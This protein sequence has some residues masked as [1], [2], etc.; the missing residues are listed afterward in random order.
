MYLIHKKSKNNKVDK[1]ARI[2]FWLFVYYSIVHIPYITFN[3]YS[4]PMI[5]IFI[6]SSAFVLNNIISKRKN[7]H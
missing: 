7:N 1:T 3:R 2:L 5:W 4:Y 6:I